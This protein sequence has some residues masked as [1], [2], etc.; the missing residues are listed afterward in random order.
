MPKELNSDPE[1][2]AYLARTRGA[3]GYVS[4]DASTEGVKVLVVSDGRS[5]ERRLLTRVE[6]EYPETLSSFRSA[7][8]CPGR[9]HFAEGYRRESRLTGKQSHSC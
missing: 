2:V 8:P 3:T 9:H 7:A 1:V 4:G 5:A 6:P